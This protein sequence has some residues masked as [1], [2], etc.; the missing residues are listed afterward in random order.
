MVESSSFFDGEIHPYT[1]SVP[2]VF[3]GIGGIALAAASS[4]WRCARSR[5]CPSGWTRRPAAGLMR[6]RKRGRKA[7][8]PVPAFR[9]AQIFGKTTVSIGLAAELSRRGSPCKHSRRPGYIDPMWSRRSGRTCRNLDFNL[10]TPEQLQVEFGAPWRR[11]AD[12][13]WSKAT[14]GLYD[15]LDLHGRTACGAAQLLD[16]PVCWCIDARA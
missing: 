12:C 16:L 15:G 11:P 3:L 4:P 6:E 5:Y 9:C 14:K 1:P 10:S 7:H 2:E 8:A 13:V